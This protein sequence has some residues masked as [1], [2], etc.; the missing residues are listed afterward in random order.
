MSAP[1]IILA[2]L[3]SF[4]RNY[5]N[6]WKFEEVLTKTILHSFLRTVGY[7]MFV[8]VWLTR[9]SAVNKTYQASVLSI[10]SS[11]TSLSPVDASEPPRQQ[12]FCHQAPVQTMYVHIL[13]T[14]TVAC[15]LSL[16]STRWCHCCVIHTV[17]ATWLQ[18][19]MLDDWSLPNV[20]T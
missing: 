12:H 10:V 20:V 11:V 15:Q 14:V 2:S 6:W 16:W 19:Y 4:C 17:T 1:C 9:E 3:P 18:R 13:Y 5:Q 7:T 8:V